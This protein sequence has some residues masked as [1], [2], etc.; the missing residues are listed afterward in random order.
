[1]KRAGA[2]S[3]ICERHT[4]PRSW[5]GFSK[6]PPL[7]ISTTVRL[8]VQFFHDD[9]PT[10]SLAVRAYV[11]PAEAMQHDVLFDIWMRF[12]DHSYRTLPPRPGNDRVLGELTLSLPGLH[13]ATAFVPDSSAYHE[14]FHLLYAGDAGIALSRDHRFVEVHFV[15]SNGAPAL[16]G[17]YLVDM[18]HAADI[19]SSEEHVVKN[20]RQFIPLAGVTDLEPG[21]LIGTCCGPLLRVPLQIIPSDTPAPS[22]L[23]CD[24]RA[25]HLTVP[26]PVAAPSMDADQLLP[27]PVPG[28]LRPPSV[29][30]SSAM[31]RI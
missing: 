19:F 17:C 27:P 16:A 12:N 14:S 28:S 4:P 5:G 9:R 13:G 20:G 26:G 21:A 30:N 11:V 24:P 7:Q 23:P 29:Q 8:S 2:A 15:R 1:M 6:S 31:R 3:D 18:L 25:Q 22:P 10:A